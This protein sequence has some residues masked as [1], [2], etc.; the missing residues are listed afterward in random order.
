MPI[1]GNTD[2]LG[3]NSRGKVNRSRP[4]YYD[5]YNYGPTLLGYEP[6]DLNVH[7]PQKNNRG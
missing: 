4:T 1:W 2:V 3:Q 5:I 6:A 7:P